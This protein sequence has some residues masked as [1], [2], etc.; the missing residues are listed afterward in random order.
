M[1]AALLLVGSVAGDGAGTGCE[2]G[3]P[4]APWPSPP[5]QEWVCSQIARAE[6]L[7]AGSVPFLA[8]TNSVKLE[9]NLN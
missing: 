8:G 6:D 7:S 5:W 1:P 9:S 2:A 3:F 4:S